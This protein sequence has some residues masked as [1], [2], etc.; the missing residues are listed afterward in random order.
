MQDTQISNAEPVSTITPVVSADTNG[1]RS[2]ANSFLVVLLPILL[3]VSVAI[4]GFFAFQTQKLVKELQEVR[5]EKISIPNVVVEPTYTPVATIDLITGWKTYNNEGFFTFQYPSDYTESGMGIMSPL[6]STV[7]YKDAT[8]H[9]GELKL[10]FY[11]EKFEGNMTV[12]SCWKDHVSGDGEILSK[13]KVYVGNV[14]YETII[15]QGLGTG[16][17][18]CLANNGYRLL[19]NKYPAETTRQ[20]DYEKILSTFKFTN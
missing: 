15:W 13:K 14:S 8:L 4:A 5:N 7:N 20:D 19:I 6:N 12:E 10:E 1:Q 3:F 9:D 2:K 17:F 11:P 18:T 16:E